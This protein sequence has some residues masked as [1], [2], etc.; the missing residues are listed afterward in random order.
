MRR[1]L[2]THSPRIVSAQLLTQSSSSCFENQV[3]NHLL[4]PLD[5]SPSSVAA[6]FLPSADQVI[7]NITRLRQ[8]AETVMA[9]W[10]TE[11]RTLQR[12]RTS[13]HCH[14]GK[15][16]NDDR[17]EAAWTSL[18]LVTS[19]FGMPGPSTSIRH[20]R[21]L[22]L[23]LSRS[24]SKRQPPCFE[25]MDAGHESWPLTGT[26]LRLGYADRRSSIGSLV[27]MATLPSQGTQSRAAG[28][29]GPMESYGPTFRR[30]STHGAAFP[31]PSCTNLPS[32]CRHLRNFEQRTCSSSC[33][34]CRPRTPVFSRLWLPVGSRVESA[35]PRGLSGGLPVLKLP[36]LR[37]LSA[38][39]Y[40]PGYLAQEQNGFEVVNPLAC[41]SA[42]IRYRLEVCP[43]KSLFQ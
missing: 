11:M 1:R 34:S 9:D 22:A 16:H 26:V 4:Q 18:M 33:S 14:P 23:L 36:T 10:Q 41:G 32:A 31:S 28:D 37:R 7:E 8:S 24:N 13:W 6:V 15:S 29:S 19:M 5:R 30:P 40:T 27:S 20:R 38:V 25:S 42:H 35:T 21:L 12:G 43:P 17:R 2:L 39:T 3:V